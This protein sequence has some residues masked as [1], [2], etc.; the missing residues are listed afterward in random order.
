MGMAKGAMDVFRLATIVQSHFSDCSC[1]P[2]CRHKLISSKRQAASPAHGMFHAKK[3]QPAAARSRKRAFKF[4][5]QIAS[6]T[7]AAAAT[8]T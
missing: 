5:A 7:T 8:T 1:T 2:D 4:T 3:T 6:F